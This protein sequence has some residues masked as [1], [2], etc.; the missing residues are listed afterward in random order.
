MLEEPFRQIDLKIAQLA[1]HSGCRTASEVVTRSVVWSRC[2]TESIN[3]RP[4]PMPARRLIVQRSTRG[5]TLLPRQLQ[6]RF[7]R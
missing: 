4:P 7:R 3:I 5:I 1:R 6:L 2:R